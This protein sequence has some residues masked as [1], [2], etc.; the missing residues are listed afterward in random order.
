MMILSL[1][2][3]A[4]LQLMVLGTYIISIHAFPIIFIIIASY[5]YIYIYIYLVDNFSLFILIGYRS[6]L[7]QDNFQ[8][9]QKLDLG[10]W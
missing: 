2:M 4:E 1:K 5:I 9:H 8:L 7:S 3:T 10:Y 6:Y